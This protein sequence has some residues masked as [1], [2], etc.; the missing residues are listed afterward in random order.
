MHSL[1]LATLFFYA[2][3]SVSGQIEATF[4][5]GLDVDGVADE[6]ESCNAQEQTMTLRQVPD[7]PDSTEDKIIDGIRFRFAHDGTNVYLLAVVK[8]P[9]YFNLTAG[10]RFSNAIAVMWKVG[11]DATMFNMGGCSVPT[12]PDASGPYDCE[13][14][15]ENCD[16]EPTDCSCNTSLVDVWHLETGRPGA[17]PGVLYPYRGPV[18]HPND[19]GSYRTLGYDPERLGMYQPSVQRL[20]SGDDPTSNS[21]DEFAV[22]PCLREDD[23]S[24][25]SR[26]RSHRRSQ[27]VFYRNQ[28]RFAWSHTAI[29]SHEYPFGPIGGSGYYIYEFSRPLVTNENTDVQLQ[30]GISAQ[31]A[32]AFWMPPSIGEEWGVS[33]HYVAPPDFQFGT[34]NLVPQPKENGANMVTNS[35]IVASLSV[36]LVAVMTVD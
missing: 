28:L 36:I 2:V 14:I 6:W 21:D 13:K 3:C 31:F 17:I 29:N 35:L 16:L 19:A 11:K 27:G 1:V 9:Y 32:L 25:R 8:G 24:S 33:A 7:V 12:P 4:C 20:F 30:V 34:L 10:N 5:L 18:V 15:K 26:V 22:H 23:G